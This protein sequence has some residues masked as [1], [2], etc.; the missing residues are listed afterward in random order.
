VVQPND[1]QPLAIA[2]PAMNSNAHHVAAF[3]NAIV[4]ANRSSGMPKPIAP[5][6]P[7]RRRLIASTISYAML[8]VKMRQAF[9]ECNA[10]RLPSLSRN[11]AR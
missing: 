6:S 4:L 1:L 9:C 5:P 3:L 7:A 11:T 8:K 10:I 2:A